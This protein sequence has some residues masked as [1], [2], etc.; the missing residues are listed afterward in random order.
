MY[1]PF[2]ACSEHKV[3]AAITR[4]GQFFIESGLENYTETS[5]MFRVCL[6]L[7]LW[8]G[9]NTPLTLGSP[10][11]KGKMHWNHFET[12]DRAAIGCASLDSSYG[13]VEIRHYGKIHRRLTNKLNAQISDILIKGKGVD[14]FSSNNS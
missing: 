7:A 11:Q 8:H 5:P 3:A 2:G 12:V 13:F 14:V 10:T 9:T 6:T 4:I 1:K